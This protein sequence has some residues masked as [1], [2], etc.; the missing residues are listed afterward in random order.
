M[1]LGRQKRSICCLFILFLLLLGMCTDSVQA[2]SSFLCADSLSCGQEDIF[3]ASAIHSAGNA[4]PFEQLFESA[5]VRQC[6]LTTVLRPSGSAP[7][8]RPGRGS[9]YAL[10]L[11]MSGQKSFPVFSLNS[12]YVYREAASNTVIISYIHRQ[13]GQKD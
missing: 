6:E 3:C 8:F 5:S 12:I 2:D 10:S 11:S 1:Q 13:D 7:R 9:S 4:A